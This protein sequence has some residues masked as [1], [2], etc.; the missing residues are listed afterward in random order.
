MQILGF[1]KPDDAECLT[2]ANEKKEEIFLHQTGF[3]L[4]FVNPQHYFHLISHEMSSLLPF[5]R[6]E[7]HPLY[8]YS[9][10]EHEEAS[11][12]LS[13]LWTRS[14]RIFLRPSVGSVLYIHAGTSLMRS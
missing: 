12:V 1:L 7:N 3:A 13:I 9:S 10:Q 6:P 2:M 8:A 11:D 4:S 14:L 5:L